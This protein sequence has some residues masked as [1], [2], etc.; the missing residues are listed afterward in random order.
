MEEDEEEDLFEDA[1]TDGLW[2]QSWTF[3]FVMWYLGIAVKMGEIIYQQ[4]L[5]LSFITGVSAVFIPM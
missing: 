4:H 2:S 3:M 1:V 5:Q